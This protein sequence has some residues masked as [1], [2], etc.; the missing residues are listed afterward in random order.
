MLSDLRTA[1]WIAQRAPW[2]VSISN[3]HEVKTGDSSLKASGSKSGKKSVDVE[4]G[5]DHNNI[6][7]NC[8]PVDLGVL[9]VT[10]LVHS[11]LSMGSFTLSLRG[12]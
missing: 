8:G 10:N 6:T 1:P 3:I 7:A 11:C 5:P 4:C 2:D 12:L 9:V